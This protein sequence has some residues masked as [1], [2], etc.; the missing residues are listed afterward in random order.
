MIV[1]TNVLVNA[2]VNGV[3]LEFMK[4]YVLVVG[5]IFQ[6]NWTADHIMRTT[7]N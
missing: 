3:P 5:S 2:T 1:F 7:G 6:D 4:G